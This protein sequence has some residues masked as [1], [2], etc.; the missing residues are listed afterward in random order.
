MAFGAGGKARGMVSWHNIYV[1]G[2][3]SSRSASTRFLIRR[4]TQV[5]RAVYREKMSTDCAVRTQARC[6]SLGDC[7]DGSWPDGER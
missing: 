7:K 1:A 5:L 4:I 2:D 3:N 6:L